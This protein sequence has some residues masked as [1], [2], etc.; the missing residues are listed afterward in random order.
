MDNHRD[1]SQVPSVPLDLVGRLAAE[2]EPTRSI[3]YKRVGDRELLLHLFHPRGWAPTD[4]RPCFL[5][6]HGGG[7]T[8]MSPRRMYPFA[9]HFARRG[10]VGVSVQY[11]LADPAAGVTVFECVQ[12]ARSAMRYVRTHARELGIEA[13]RI[14]AFGGSAGGHLAAATG[15]FDDVNEPTDD[16]GIC[17]VPQ[18][19]VL[20]FPVIDT[21]P[22]GYGNKLIGERW[23]ELSPLHRVR[24]GLP[25]TL[26]FHGTG[27]AV[28]PFTGAQAF[29]DAMRQAGNRCE[30]DAHDG[31][32]HGYLMRDRSLLTAML[33]KTETFLVS[34]GMLPASGRG[35]ARGRR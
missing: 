12:D 6:I 31:G 9:A 4:R 28:T 30:L 35:G 19:M 10:M 27:D 2:L 17:P 16:A 11:R 25:P 34:L 20:I 29:H 32:G 13:D 14:V 8:G 26:L 3:P 1:Q 18:A 33:R 21:S 24:P 15:M 7:W 23:R 22:A 5:A